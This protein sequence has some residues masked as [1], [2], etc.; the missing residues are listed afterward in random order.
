MDITPLIPA[1]RQV[2]DAY[3]PGRFRVSNTVYETPIIVFPD[4]TLVWA[5]ENF[6][7]LEPE[8]FAA[9][10]AEQPEIVLLGC[11]PTMQLFPSSLRR[12]LKE[13]GLGGIDPM[14][15]GAACRTYNVLMAEGRRVAAA[16]LPA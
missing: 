3:G 16:L 10:T 8:D 7:D 13:Q 4:R 9:L 2:I 6:A 1:D 14:D 11:G 15:T 12:A 5:V